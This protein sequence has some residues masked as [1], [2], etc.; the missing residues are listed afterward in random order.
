MSD[1][2][3]SPK[4]FSSQVLDLYEKKRIEG[5]FSARVQ[6]HVVARIGCLITSWAYH[7]EAVRRAVYICFLSIT[8]VFAKANAQ[9]INEQKELCFHAFK[10]SFQYFFASF[11]PSVLDSIVNEETS[12][13][14]ALP[15]QQIET[16]FAASFSPPPCQFEYK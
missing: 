9:L 11:D 6:I 13:L 15:I 5:S 4:Q 3:L 16:T 12:P 7:A 2:I 8:D 1:M 14:K 10:R